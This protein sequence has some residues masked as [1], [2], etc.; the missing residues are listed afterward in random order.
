MERIAGGT[1]NLS[2]CSETIADSW[3]KA[4]MVV[5]AKNTGGGQ[6]NNERD[7]GIEYHDNYRNADCEHDVALTS[8]NEAA[9]PRNFEGFAERESSAEVARERRCKEYLPLVQRNQSR[10]AH[11]QEIQP[12]RL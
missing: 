11:D 3:N 4:E 6:G 7:T 8:E 2:G 12:I 5:P 9:R 10:A 1:R